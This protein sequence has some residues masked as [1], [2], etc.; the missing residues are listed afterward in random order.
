MDD[1]VLM[2][3]ENCLANLPDDDLHFSEGEGGLALLHEGVE[4][5]EAG[6]LLNKVDLVV[7][8][9]DPVELHDVDVAAEVLDLQLRSQAVHHLQLAEA[10]L[11]HDLKSV[12][13]AGLAFDHLK[14]FAKGPLSQLTQQ[15]KVFY[16]W[17]ALFLC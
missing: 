8:I 3:E 2:E 10:L 9:E 16:P 13:E 4:G 11:L 15:L 7:V 6:V 1:I 17:N 12:D 5:L 14:H